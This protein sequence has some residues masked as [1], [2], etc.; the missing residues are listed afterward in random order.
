MPICRKCKSESVEPAQLCLFSGPMYLVNYCQTC[1]HVT[2]IGGSVPD[3][4]D[5]YKG[6]ADRALGRA[7]FGP[8]KSKKGR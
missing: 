3:V 6:Y 5:K 7:K 2:R 8:R 1:E 4:G